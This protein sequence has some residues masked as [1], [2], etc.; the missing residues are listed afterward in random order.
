ME[1][2]VAAAALARL[3]VSVP[4]GNVQ[5]LPAG[6]DTIT[7]DVRVEALDTRGLPIAATGLLLVA[8]LLQARPV[9]GPP[10]RTRPRRCLQQTKPVCLRAADGCSG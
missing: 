4:A 10:T 1:L 7:V 8:E 9:I 5:Q 2:T 3:R 6:A